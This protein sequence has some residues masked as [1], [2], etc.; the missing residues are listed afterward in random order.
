[1]KAKLNGKWYDV[2]TKPLPKRKLDINWKDHIDHEKKTISS[3][4]VVYFGDLIKT[5]P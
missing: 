1:M 5:K 2:V 3:G 4:L